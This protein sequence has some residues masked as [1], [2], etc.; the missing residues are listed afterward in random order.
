MSNAPEEDGK[1]LINQ[2]QISSDRKRKLTSQSISPDKFMDLVAGEFKHLKKCNRIIKKLEKLAFSD[3]F[4]FGLD[5]KDFFKFYEIMLKDKN[6][7]LSF[8][9]KL[10]ESATKNELLRTY[11]EKQKEETQGGMP[12]DTRIRRVVN[13]I[14]AR[15]KE[16]QTQIKREEDGVSGDN[17]LS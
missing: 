2:V 4:I 12:Q 3:E 1:I 15:A 13:E 7:S 9:A 6:V 10:Y 5:V 16:A 17:E 11:F 8:Y 14:R